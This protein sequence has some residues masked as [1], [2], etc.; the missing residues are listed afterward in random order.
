[1][2]VPPEAVNAAQRRA[3]RAAAR[4]FELDRASQALGMRITGT[5]WVD[6][7]ITLE[8]AGTFAAR[9]RDIGFD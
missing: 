5:D 2:G 1:M 7:G 3:E 6:G 8:E 4:L 9:L